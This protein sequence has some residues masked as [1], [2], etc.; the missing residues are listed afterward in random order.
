MNVLLF[1]KLGAAMGRH[2]TV[3]VPSDGCSVSELRHLI[4]SQHA[5]IADEIVSA[6]VRAFVDDVV[7]AEGARIDPRQ[8]VEFFPPVSGG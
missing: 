8:T 3:A 4:A 1:G 6:R 2:V 7:V 5:S